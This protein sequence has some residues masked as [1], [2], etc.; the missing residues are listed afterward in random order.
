MDWLEK[1]RSRKVSDDN[2]KDSGADRLVSETAK[3]P[4]RVKVVK[5]L[6]SGDSTINNED[7]QSK[8]RTTPLNLSIAG[9]TVTVEVA[10]EGFEH[11][12]EGT[13]HK[14]DEDD[15]GRPHKDNRVN[16]IGDGC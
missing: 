10:L 11:L 1:F 14:V 8:I 9:Q 13:W 6:I 5:Y 12:V 4:R 7:E 3:K 15:G 2:V 16:F